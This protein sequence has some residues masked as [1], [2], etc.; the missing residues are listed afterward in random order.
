MPWFPTNPAILDPEHEVHGR[1]AKRDG[2]KGVELLFPDAVGK[3]RRIALL[4]A[5]VACAGP[6]PAPSRLHRP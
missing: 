1:V 4:S 2:F 5:C 3:D 6:E